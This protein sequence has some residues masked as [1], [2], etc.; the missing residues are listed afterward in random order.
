MGEISDDDIKFALHSRLAHCYDATRLMGTVWFRAH[1]RLTNESLHQN[2]VCNYLREPLRLFPDNDRLTYH[3]E[4]ILNE[5]AYCGLTV[6][7]SIIVLDI[8][9][10]CHVL[11][12]GLPYIY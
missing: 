5:S 4:Q 3:M 9:H 10:N 7:P 1:E 8:A 12:I 6:S 11:Y 2:E